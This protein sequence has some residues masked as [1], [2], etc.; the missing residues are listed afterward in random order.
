MITNKELFLRLGWLPNKNA[1]FSPVVNRFQFNYKLFKDK[2]IEIISMIPSD[3]I[4]LLL[5]GGIDS[6]LIGLYAKEAGKN[7]IAYTVA[8]EKDDGEENDAALSAKLLGFQ[9]KIVR[10]SEQECL[11]IFEKYINSHEKIHAE[12]SGVPLA[13]LMKRVKEDGFDHI[14]LGDGG[15]DYFGGYVFFKLLYDF[16]KVLMDR[17]KSPHMRAL[18]LYGIYRD[19]MN[20]SEYKNITNSEP[21]ESFDQFVISYMEQYFK[22][23]DLIQGLVDFDCYNWLEQAMIPK[24]EAGCKMYNIEVHSPFLNPLIIP[25]SYQLDG[26]KRVNKKILREYMIGTCLDKLVNKPKLGF[27]PPFINWLQRDPWKSYLLDNLDGFNKD[28]IVDNMLGDFVGS[29]FAFRCLVYNIKNN[30]RSNL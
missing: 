11:N 19:I 23:N 4:A 20:D 3:K 17:I 1:Y 25:M 24:V 7:V 14:L 30:K 10:V 13:I 16:E 21:N 9:H 29:L 2:I 28:Y 6:S 18:R 15:D 22:D 26:D 12:W 8:Y 27:K 5:S